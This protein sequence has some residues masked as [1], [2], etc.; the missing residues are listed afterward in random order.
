MKLPQNKSILIAVLIAVISVLWLLTGIF[1][2]KAPIVAKSVVEQKT[3]QD[4]KVLISEQKA[5]NH[6]NILSLY[7]QTEANRTVEI[8]AETNGRVAEILIEKGAQVKAGDVI[9]RLAMD[10]RNRRLKSA[11]AAVH[12]RSLE[13]EASRKLSQKSFRSQTKLAESESA[14]QSARA[15]LE[16]I[17]L[18]ISHTDI[19]APFDGKLENTSIEVG[20]YVSTGT[21]VASIVDLSPIVV[22]AEIP[23]K[24]ILKVKDGQQAYAVLNDGSEIHGIIRFVASASDKSTRTYRVELE[25][26]NPE[27]KIAAG[28]TA[29]LRL[30]VGRYHAYRVSPAILTL[31]KQGKVG[32]K[33]VDREN[34]VVFYPVTLIEDTPDGIWVSGLP[35]QARIITRG[36][37]YVSTGQKVV[38]VSKGELN[39]GTYQETPPALAKA[40]GK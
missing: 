28:L 6:P 40:Q 8:K 2:E 15:E 21:Q 14:L 34:R 27:Q 33:T 16:S 29:R 22:S 4:I 1:E 39:S 23:E 7:G 36:Q 31:N 12:F 37:E 26:E 35:E 17:R 20:D 11:Q 13:Y 10:D 3:V 30:E 38:A 18:D 5:T 24:D 9:A 25:G 32:I 19:K